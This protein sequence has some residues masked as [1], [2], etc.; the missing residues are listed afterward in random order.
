[1]QMP[2]NT[3]LLKCRVSGM[4]T[5]HTMPLIF[6]LIAF[7]PALAHAATVAVIDEDFGF[8]R[9]H[10]DNYLPG[11]DIQGSEVC[12]QL[13]EH[14]F[15][16]YPASHLPHRWR[17]NDDS[18]GYRVSRA[19]L[20]AHP[21]ARVRECSFV[22]DPKLTH[23]SFDYLL[24]SDCTQSAQVVNI[25]LGISSEWNSL[26]VG[27]LAG[28]IRAHN[29]VVVLSLPNPGQESMLAKKLMGAENVVLAYDPA[30]P[31]A[32]P[33]WARHA[34]NLAEASGRHGS[35]S[36]NSFAAGHVSGL[37]SYWIDQGLT[38]R[39]AARKTLKPAPPSPL[40]ERQRGRQSA[41]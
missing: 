38:P 30:L 28:I 10:H 4:L 1:M 19:V 12:K 3:F 41:W 35:S 24:Q 36:G 16:V 9:E 23:L 39:E 27:K 20:A 25:S 2:N 37:I 15:F 32:L 40:N 6:L 17:Y 18:H 7:L 5:S 8:P 29:G 14:F 33:E 21:E 13:S 31:N 22:R 11:Y 26:P 34:P